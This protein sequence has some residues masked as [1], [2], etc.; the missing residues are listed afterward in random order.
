M[1]FETLWEPLPVGAKARMGAAEA[2]RRPNGCS[3][4]RRCGNHRR[5]VVGTIVVSLWEK[6]LCPSLRCVLVGIPYGPCGKPLKHVVSLWEL[7]SVLRFAVP[8][9]ATLQFTQL[10]HA[11]WAAPLVSLHPYHDMVV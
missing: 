9:W 3:S 5:V 7:N 2:K 4:L 11:S 1:L 10:L 8:L 6:L